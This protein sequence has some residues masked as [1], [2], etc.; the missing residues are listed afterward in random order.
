MQAFRYLA[1]ATT[2]F[3][4]ACWA[5]PAE[6]QYPE[7][8]VRMIVPFAPGGS[9][10]VFARLVS[11]KLSQ[12]LGKQFY[13]ENVAGASGNIGTGQAA[14]AAPDGHTVLLAFSSFVINPSLFASVPYD[15]EKSFD[16]V[17]LAVSAT[18]VVTVTPSVPAT[19]I[20]ELVSLIKAN[21]GKYSYAHGGAGTPGHLLG[22]LFRL[23]AN[24]DIVP[25]PF[26]GA[27]PAITSVLGGHTPIGIT[28][29]SPAASQIAGGQLRALATTGTKRARTLTSVPTMVEA[30]HPDIVGDLWVGVLVPTGTSKEITALLNRE[31]KDI[32]AQAET[33]ER[34]TM[35]GFEAVASTPDAFAEQIK[36]ELA[37]WRAVIQDAKIKAP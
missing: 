35:V 14:K 5:L 21:P 10:D 27:G 34:L 20:P 6:A 1:Y 18:H 16:P 23:K 37:S 12:K 3:A 8:P 26:N 11:D 9:V 13:V 15:A 36:R 2:I 4:A 28:A 33:Q 22:E 24:V 31:L 19:T 17:M 30:G 7:K 29:L 25:V 32:L